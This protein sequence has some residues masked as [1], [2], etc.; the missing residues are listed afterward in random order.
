MEQSLSWEANSSSSSEEIPHI[1]WSPKV[2][3]HI[4]NSPPPVPVLSQINPVRATPSH[5]LK[6]HFNIIILST[7]WCSNLS[8]TLRLPHQNPART[9]HIPYTC[10]HAIVM[11]VKIYKNYIWKVWDSYKTQLYCSQIG[12]RFFIDLLVWQ[13]VSTHSFG[14]SSGLQDVRTCS[15]QL[16][17]VVTYI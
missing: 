7:F 11:Y 3:H 8:L 12:L 9:S 4:H 10:P 6:I 2:H 14:P 17:F 1:L 13:H 15:S 5:F 16:L